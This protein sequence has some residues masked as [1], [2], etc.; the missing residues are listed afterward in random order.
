MKTITII[1]TFAFFF[2]AY[3]ALPPLKSK[4]GFPTG[5]LTGFVN[6]IHQLQ[7]N[8]STDYIIFALDSKEEGFRKKIYPD[9]KAN[10]PEPPE[11]LKE[12]LIVAID[13]IEKMGFK[14]ITKDGF[15]ADDV[16]AT[17][18][19]YAKEQNIVAKLVSSDKDLYQLLDDSRVYLYDWV[20]K[21]DIDEEACIK[22]FGV[23]ILSIFT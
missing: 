2:R 19:K 18:S 12:Q 6:F 20:K 23:P 10:R 21:K 1:D 8:H 4:S 22:K 15:E 13:W 14:A 3:Y 9:Y 11:D 16:M 5:L 7:S 17:V